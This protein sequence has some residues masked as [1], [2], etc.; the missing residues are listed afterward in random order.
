MLEMYV[1]YVMQLYKKPLLASLGQIRKEY[2]DVDQVTYTQKPAVVRDV[3]SDSRT[4]RNSQS[5]SE[6]LGDAPPSSSMC[7]QEMLHHLPQCV[8]RRFSTIFLNVSS[9]DAPPSSS[10]CPQEMLHHLPQCVLRS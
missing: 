8:L 3:D 2:E 5:S 4:S 10:M 9:G 6:H 1:C 7:P